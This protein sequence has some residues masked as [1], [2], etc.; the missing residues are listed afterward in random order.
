MARVS[1]YPAEFTQ[2]RAV[3]VQRNLRGGQQFGIS[4][5]RIGHVRTA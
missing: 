3:L 1:E 4:V 2:H 5:R